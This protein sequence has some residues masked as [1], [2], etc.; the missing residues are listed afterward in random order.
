MLNDLDL[1]PYYD[2]MRAMP[3]GEGK[4]SSRRRQ[5]R[6]LEEIERLRQDLRHARNWAS[7]HAAD[8]DLP[9]GLDTH[10]NDGWDGRIAGFG[11]PSTLGIL[12]HC[13]YCIEEPFTEVL[14]FDPD[15][16][17]VRVGVCITHL[18]QLAKR[19][20]DAAEALKEAMDEDQQ[21][22]ALD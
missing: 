11:T 6:L 3:I 21:A 13:A 17:A 8:R 5:A 10:A 7:H 1:V 14:S 20:I 22:T 9:P 2:L 19:G 12:G 16:T 15:E 4:D 18:A